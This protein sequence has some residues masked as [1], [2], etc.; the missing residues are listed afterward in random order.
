MMVE[1]RS[2]LSSLLEYLHIEDTV[3]ETQ[4]VAIVWSVFNP[5]VLTI[6]RYF[7]SEMNQMIERNSRN[8]DLK[9]KH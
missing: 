8:F 4:V 7:S 5:T 1:I 6:S 9:L 3:M 2:I